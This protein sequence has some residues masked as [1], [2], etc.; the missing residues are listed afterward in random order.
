[1]K[2]FILAAVIGMSMIGSAMASDRHYRPHR[3]H[4]QHHGHHHH[5]GRHWVA[6]LIIGGAIGYG[7]TRYYSP[8]PVYYPDAPVIMHNPPLPAP[9]CT[10]YIYQDSYGNT[11]REE[12]RCE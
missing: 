3:P 7:V 4:V 2:K 5:H 6:P 12:T 1:M 10:R 8:P 9:Q 11:I